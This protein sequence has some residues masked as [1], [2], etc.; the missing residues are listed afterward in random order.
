MSANAATRVLWAPA[1][2]PRTV[3]P[4]PAAIWD[5]PDNA[6]VAIHPGLGARLACRSGT[7]VV[8]QEGDPLDHLL[9]AGDRLEAS[10]KGLV[11]AWALR[12]GVLVLENGVE[13]AERVAPSP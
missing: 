10:S 4:A 13:Q 2:R 8:T 1:G 6:T 11:V 7:F 5:L 3:R 12:Q 9:E